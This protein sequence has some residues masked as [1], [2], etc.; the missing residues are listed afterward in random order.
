VCVGR[1]EESCT[2]LFRKQLSGRADEEKEGGEKR[3]W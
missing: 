3:R 2:Q 1:E